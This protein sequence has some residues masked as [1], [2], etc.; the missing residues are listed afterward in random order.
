MPFLPRVARLPCLVRYTV[1][2]CEAHVHL[3]VKPTL[4]HKTGH[5]Q[6]KT[7]FLVLSPA[8]VLCLAGHVASL[9][10][11]LD[12]NL[13]GCLFSRQNGWPYAGGWHAW[14]YFWAQ[15]MDRHSGQI[16]LRPLSVLQLYEHRKATRRS[17]RWS[18]HGGG[19]RIATGVA[20][21]VAPA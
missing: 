8:P 9:N 1:P 17:S 4:S 16:K 3:W 7:K 2:D 13:T 18:G 19:K 20:R 15:E 6:L 12:L 21:G 5:S 11:N 10:L 14:A